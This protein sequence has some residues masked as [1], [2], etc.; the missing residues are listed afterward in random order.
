MNDEQKHHFLI[1]VSLKCVVEG[2]EWKCQ[3]GLRLFQL[4]LEITILDKYRSAVI[5]KF[6]CRLEVVL[7]LHVHFL[8]WSKLEQLILFCVEKK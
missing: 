1:H 5:K 8:K 3:E 2:R 4:S 7:E 6:E